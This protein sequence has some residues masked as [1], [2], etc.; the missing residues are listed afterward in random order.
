[1][2]GQKLPFEIGKTDNFFTKLNEWVGDVFYDILPEAGFELRDEQI[3]MA[4]QLEKAFKEKQVVFAEAGVGTGKTIVYL[5]YAVCYARFTG[6]P[7]IIACADETLIEQ[8]VKKEGDIAKLASFLELTVDARLAK[9][10]NQYLCLKKLDDRMSGDPSIKEEDLFDMLPDFVHDHSGMQQFN[11]YGDRKDYAHFTDEEWGNVSWDHFQDCFACSK[12]HRCGQTLSRDHYRK[13]TDIIICSHDFYMEHI[14]TVESRKREGQLPLLPEASCVVFDEGHLV[15]IAAQKALTYRIKERTLEEL[16]TRLLGN[17]LREEFAE[18]VELVVQDN[19]VFFHE[20][21]SNSTKV[22]G[23]N[24][25]EITFSNALLEQARILYS[26]IVEIGEALVFEEQLYT[27]NHYDLHIVEEHLDQ[28]E[29]SLKLFLKTEDVIS[30]VELDSDSYH[31]VIMP[32]T[33]QEVLDEQVFSQRIPFVFSSA[34]LSQNSQF[35]Y[36]A[37]S[38]GIKKYSSFT[39]DSPFDYVE[40]MKIYMKR[41][42]ESTSFQQKFETAMQQIDRTKGRALLLFTSNEELQEFKR[43]VQLNETY[44]FLFEGD[45]EISELVSIF[46]NEEETILCAVHLWEGLD[47][48]GPSLSNIIIWSLP[49]PPHD[50]VFQSKRKTAKDYVW[51]VEVP[52]M[53][54]RLR[55]GIGRLIRT[56]E[57]NGIVT[58]MVPESLDVAILEVIKEVCQTKPIFL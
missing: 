6:K 2:I 16:L 54:L 34:T 49:F 26:R 42:G 51:D 27:I 53:L 30:W 5:L 56:Q 38:L 33:V 43:G 48:P 20:L 58:I 17:N 4:F 7:A 50:P 31:L 57:D 9:S 23:S 14:W 24:R 15:E 28:L 55:Q 36:I 29:H 8:L 22:A 40:K 21:K 41:F 37:D 47:I 44:T 35:D 39:V 1:M 19:E 52:Y 18:L 3:F 13:A 10:P 45:R 11:H 32:R 25:V 46:Q 12:R